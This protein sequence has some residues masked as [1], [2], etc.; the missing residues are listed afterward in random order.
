MPHHTPPGPKTTDARERVLL[1]G[2]PNV[3]KSVL[4]NLL[5][6]QYVVV[7]NYP[8][9]TV[10]VA[11]GTI[12]VGRKKLPIVDTPG[13][14]NLIP[15]SEDELVTRNMLLEP[16]DQKVVQVADMKNL[17]RALLITLQLAEMDVPLVLDLN[18]GD[19]GRSR[20]I[21]VDR[22][23][24]SELLG[25]EVV[26]TVATRKTGLEDLRKALL[27]CRRSTYKIS[28]D[29]PISEGVRQ[30]A[31]LLPDTH[32]PK[33]ALALMLLAGDQSLA[34]WLQPRMDADASLAI[35]EVRR[36]V[37]S[38]YS[39]PLSYVLT[40]RRLAAANT[41][42]QRVQT[43]RGKARQPWMDA[44]GHLMVHPLWGIPFLI[45][46]LY[47]TYKFVGQFGAGTS[48]DFMEGFVFQ[49]HINPFIT[50]VVEAAIPVPLLRELLVGQY[51]LITV[52]LTYSFAIVLPIVGYFFLVF[53]LLEDT[54]Y[55]PRLAVMVNTI[56][57]AMGVSGKAVLPMVLGLGCDTMATLT[58][59]I[60][61]TRKERLIIILLLALG[62]PCSAQLGVILGMLAALSTKATLLWLGVVLGTIFAVGCLAS[63]VLPGE[64]ADFI[65]EIPPLR[66]PVLS[67]VA[68]KT[69]ARIEWYLR[70]AVPL[71][72]LATF[73][74]FLLDK[75]NLLAA[76]ERAASPVI[77]GLMGLPQQTT[78]A[79]IVGFLRRDYGAAGLFTMAKAGALDPTQTLVSLVT[80]TLFLPCIAHF[81]IIIKEAKLK[82]ALAM[83]AFIFPFAF[84]V[85]GLLNA[86]LR[87]L[88][89]SL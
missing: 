66:I 20:G 69:L 41:I 30:I 83:V 38:A 28:Y 19:E 84:I 88:E 51:G 7:S 42:L 2:N 54:G 53:C 22:K 59:R 72:I 61:E 16:Y 9:T 15:M 39:A 14:N 1:V 56:F 35:E 17:R 33:R 48:V 29:G 60:L 12:T 71:F 79:F 10:E 52:A 5:T 76:L 58:T 46:V 86:V 62:V 24:L 49:Q 4:F 27:D 85:G 25:V 3:G 47:L 11:E 75:L 74:L 64:R 21:F 67:N 40:R 82:A 70:E 32:I 81:F 89:V 65:L 13:I 26:E 68:I 78:E 6:K 45:A 36:K 23:Q 73:V 50:K 31:G 87:A 43:L 63:R 8:G 77:V 80:I 57:K 37:Q 55:L 34:T 44:L 18:M